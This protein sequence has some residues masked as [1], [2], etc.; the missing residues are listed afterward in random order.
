[1]EQFNCRRT[2]IG[3]GI[4]FNSVVDGRYKTNRI[5]VSL[6]LPLE[7]ETASVNALIPGVLRK[8][9]KSCPDFT[10]FSKKLAMF[11][12]MRVG[13]GVT[14]VGD[15]QV[16]TLSADVIDDSYALNAEPLLKEAGRILAEVVLEP[17]MEEGAFRETDIELEK[18]S[19]IDLIE[20]EI[21]EKRYYAL[22]RAMSV[23]C[24]GEPAGVNKYGYIEDVKK[25]SPRSAAEA[26][27]GLL[28]TARIEVMFVGCG[29]P[30]QAKQILEQAFSG[31]KRNPRRFDV[32]TVKKEAVLKEETD[33]MNVAQSKLVL[34]FRTAV[35]PDDEAIDAVRLMLALYGGTPSSKLFLNVREKMSLCYYCAARPNVSKGLAFVDCGVE[36][37][38]IEK[39]KAEILRQLDCIRN[40]EF[41]E[42]ELQHAKLSMVNSFRSVGDSAGAVEGWY[43]SQVLYGTQN[44]PE[45]EAEKIAGI[46]RDAVIQA[47]VNMKLDT[48]YLLTAEDDAEKGGKA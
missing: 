14:A 39:A 40:G 13:Y 18:Q 37:Q 15:C 16:M 2:R 8:G 32:F 12:G 3:D 11:Y 29:D 41:T 7:R 36:H 26:Y 22:N 24:A 19:L 6:I 46:S 47:A 28:E 23:L 27:A 9:T 43:L 33:R 30:N 4:W 34:G 38:N 48:V 17:V 44:S 42:E 5:S 45:A 21:N 1:M 31:I 10:E 25:I 35:R 20:S